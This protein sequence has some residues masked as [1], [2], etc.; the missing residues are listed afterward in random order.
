MYEPFGAVL[1][2]ATADPPAHAEHSEIA[3]TAPANFIKPV[4]FIK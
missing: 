1:D 2:G 4:G 3:T